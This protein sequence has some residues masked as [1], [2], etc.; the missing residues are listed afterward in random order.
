MIKSV[1]REHHWT[2]EQISKLN[3][4]GGDYDSLEY[5]YNDVLEVHDQLKSKK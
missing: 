4:D 1:V 3:I 5:W 2:P